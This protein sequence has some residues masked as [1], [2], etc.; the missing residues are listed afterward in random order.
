MNKRGQADQVISSIIVFFVVAVLGIAFANLS[1]G[2]GTISNMFNLGQNNPNYG[3]SGND[4]MNK[5]VMLNL[6]GNEK[7][8]FV[9]EAYLNY[10]SG[11]KLF[12][13]VEGSEMRKDLLKTAQDGECI[14]LVGVETEG[15]I[16]K[17]QFAQI[18]SIFI[19]KDDP[20]NYFGPSFAAPYREK[21][22]LNKIRVDLGER[23]YDIDYYYGKCLEGAK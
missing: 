2:A 1:A 5:K 22:M 17:E 9:M 4:F 13:I 3:L 23:Y 11:G 21:G 18:N 16:H 14:L 20:D 10:I 12:G 7:E 19:S 15:E 6:S 8:V